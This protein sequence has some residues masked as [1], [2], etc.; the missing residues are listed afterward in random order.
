MSLYGYKPKTKPALWKQLPPT[1]KTLCDVFA[2]EER[3]A[4][5]KAGRREKENAARMAQIYKRFDTSVKRCL[6]T[7]KAKDAAK[8]ARLRLYKTVAAD[9]KAANPKCLCCGPVFSRP[10]RD[11]RDIHHTRG[12]RGPLLT[13]VRFFVAACRECHNWIGDHPDGARAIGLL[14]EAGDWNRAAC[15]S[16]PNP[17]GRMGG[18]CDPCMERVV[19]AQETRMTGAQP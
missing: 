16:C 5:K 2:K 12:R 17:A 18:Y 1:G 10:A 6:K 19:A 15:P 8:K 13:D 14:C 3:D 4:K 7:Y 11:T 9:F